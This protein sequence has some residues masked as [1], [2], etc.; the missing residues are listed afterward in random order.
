MQTLKVEN[1]GDITFEGVLQQM[2]RDARPL[3][4][5]VSA[6]VHRTR[7]AVPDVCYYSLGFSWQIVKERGS[8]W[9]PVRQGLLYVTYDSREEDR[10][11]ILDGQFTEVL[12]LREGKK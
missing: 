8:T 6:A 5:T 9:K 3:N 7:D 2:E 1:K 12:M 4:F 10:V 11:V